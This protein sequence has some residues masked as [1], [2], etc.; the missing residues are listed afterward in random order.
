MLSP[1]GPDDP[2]PTVALSGDGAILLVCDHASNRVPRALQGLGLPPR[3]LEA[4][5]AWDIGAA[6][7][8]RHLARR[9]SSAAILC[10][11][12]RLVVD[13]NRDPTDA[14]S[15]P[16]L[17]DGVRIPGNED[18]RPEER[19][20]RIA[21]IFTPYHDAIE[22]QLDKCRG[23]LPALIS[24]H[25]FTPVMNGFQR[26]WHAGILWDED[27][28]IASPLMAA[29]A[30][31]PGLVIGDNQPY[32]AREPRGYT[33][34]HHATAKGL[35][36]VAIELRQDLIGEEAGASEWAT[37]LAQALIPILRGL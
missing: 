20:A 14:S 2:P 17:S 30:A 34:S 23:R 3:H 8:T 12:S 24:I 37:R 1:I 18:L 13:C 25:S 10:G 26:P 35:P 16:I 31:E 36:Q 32:S 6:A 19:A 4:H 33:V 22:I 27:G 5:I 7:V 29:L 11:Y 21:A 28:R 9:L 15:M